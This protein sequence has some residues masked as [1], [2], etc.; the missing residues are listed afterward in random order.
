MEVLYLLESFTNVTFNNAL[1]KIT[2]VL[3]FDFELEKS[4]CEE[5]NSL[6]DSL[7]LDK[8]TTVKY[9]LTKYLNK[10]G[11]LE[12]IETRRVT[13]ED[14]LNQ[15]KEKQKE[16]EIKGLAKEESKEEIARKLAIRMYM[17]YQRKGR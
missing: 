14:C 5:L 7:L 13:W 12:K 2:Q 10:V 17:Y 8:K 1:L 11:L 6:K 4:T 3:N 16:R 15:I 9:L